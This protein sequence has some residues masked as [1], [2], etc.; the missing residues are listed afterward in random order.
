MTTADP[1]PQPAPETTPAPRRRP[2]SPL[3]S[4]LRRGRRH[5]LGLQRADGHWC[6]E[7]EGD[8]I[9]ESEY[10]LLMVC[11]GRAAEPKVAKAAAQVRRTQLAGGGWA[12]FPGGAAEVNPTVKAYFALKL[13]GDSPGAAHMRAARREARRLG[14]LEACNS[15]T[16]I[17]LAMFGQYPWSRCPAVPPELILLPR[18]FP[19]NVYEMSAWSRTIVVPLSI[20][21]ATKPVFAVP[22][23]A[24]ISELRV[25]GWR[26]PRPRRRSWQAAV[27]GRVFQAVEWGLRLYERAPLPWPRRRALDAA[28]R[29]TVERLA[30]S[31]GLGAIFPPIVNSIFAFRAM[32]LP[33]DD[34]LV[35]GQVRELER[36]EIEEE[37]TLRVQPCLSPVWDTALALSTLIDAGEEPGS[38]RIQKACQWLVAH[39]VQSPGDLAIQNPAMPVGG[40]YFEYANEFYPDCDDT[41]QV[42]IG[43]AK[44]CLDDSAEQGRIEASLGRGVVWLRSMQSRNG[45]WGA[46]DRD[47][48]RQV[49]TYI[50]FADHNAMIDPPTTDV[51]A[52]VVEALL[53]AGVPPGA[54]ELRRGVE[55]LRR[56]QESDGSWYGRWGCNY[57]YG[58]WLAL[59]AL[60]RS[61]EPV[62]SPALRRGRRWIESCQNADGGWGEL[63]QSYSEPAAKG[64]GPSTACQTAW[65]LLGLMAASDLEGDGVRRGVDFLLDRQERDGGWIDRHWTGTGFPEVFYLRY[66]LYAVYFPLQALA[67]RAALR[68]G[69]DPFAPTQPL[70]QGH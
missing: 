37:E 23:G 53:R 24:A 17:Y 47:C 8:S 10:I 26:Q 60:R 32:G 31:H 64:Q 52:R 65:A 27:W 34:P 63:P 6:A 55:F 15:F 38:R 54:P 5:L 28:Y 36:L 20:L 4:A 66:H 35:A 40:W 9:L 44:A 7:L 30:G 56:E 51:T 70:G 58:T 41:G 50:P 19:W 59:S 48:D 22:E 14:G 57:L 11:Q 61:G 45:G 69:D 43:L 46:F 18:W 49:L 21:W 39:E 29:W 3:D 12:T 62:T 13:I 42:V 16:R 25:P 33:A 67:M 1:R 68:R 2:A